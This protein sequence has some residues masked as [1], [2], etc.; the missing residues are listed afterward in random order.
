MTVDSTGTTKRVGVRA[1]V[2]IEDPPKCQIA[3][4]SRETSSVH[5]VSRSATTVGDAVTEEFTVDSPIDSEGM[6][7]VFSHDNQ[8]V[9]RFSR[10][11]KQGCPC[12]LVESYD[13]PI[14]TV[15]VNDGALVLTFYLPNPGALR[16]IIVDLRSE[17]DGV[18]LSRLTRSEG[19]D[20]DESLVFVD[21]NALTER[22]REVLET[23][24]EM[25]YFSH[26]KGA[27]ATEVA[28][29]LDINRSTFAEHL[30]AAQ[31]TIL[32]VIL[33]S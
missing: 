7:E 1:E 12:E 18:S 31:S 6:E 20:S 4:V 21:R 5:S 19:A 3:K 27:N 17:F 28:D 33:D 9:Y 25:G 30:A 10:G 23:A 13:V 26:P 11:R 32:G 2:R 15:K 22:Q 14:E 8:R 24:H 29:A 16:E